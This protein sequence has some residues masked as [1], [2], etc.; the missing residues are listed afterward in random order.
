MLL[1]F[2]PDRSNSDIVNW[3]ALSVMIIEKRKLEGVD[4][5][6]ALTHFFKDRATT[7]LTKIPLYKLS[8]PTI[9]DMLVTIFSKLMMMQD[10]F[11]AFT[12][13]LILEHTISLNSFYT[14]KIKNVIIYLGHQK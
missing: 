7:C 12:F 2:D 11:H 10:H 1:N 4:L 13:F 9:K 8:W 5:I 3:C 14:N 6:I